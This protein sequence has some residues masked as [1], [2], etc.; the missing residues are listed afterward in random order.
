MSTRPARVLLVS[1]PG[2]SLRLSGWTLLVLLGSVVFAAGGTVPG[3]GS[4]ARAQTSGQPNIVL[5]VTD[6]Q[7]FD[8]LH[9]MP[10]GRRLNGVAV[11]IGDVVVVTWR[12]AFF[13]FDFDEPEDAR[14]DY[15]V[16]T[17]GFVARDGPRFL[18]LAQEVLP[19]ADGYRAITHIPRAVIEKVDAVGV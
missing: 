11:A 7:R 14:A 9:V 16:R 4:I 10:E 17:V 1:S 3:R 15:L 2:L 13:D 8:T 12:D 19:D 5:I 18:S 6:D